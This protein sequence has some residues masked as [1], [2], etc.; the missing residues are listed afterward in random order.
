MPARNRPARAVAIAVAE[1]SRRRLLAIGV[2][3]T[4]A[5]ILLASL[6]FAVL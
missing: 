1:E 4:L 5:A 6:A 3:C 2:N